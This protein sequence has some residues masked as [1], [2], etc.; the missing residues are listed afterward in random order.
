MSTPTASSLPQDLQ[1][2]LQ[3]A[4]ASLPQG[5]ILARVNFR[6]QEYNPPDPAQVTFSCTGQVTEETLQTFT[7]P[8]QAKPKVCNWKH[9]KS[10]AGELAHYFDC[11][12]VMSK[13][14]RRKLICYQS[15]NH[16]WGLYYSQAS[17][18]DTLYND[19]LLE[20]EEKWQ[21]VKHST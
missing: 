21:A 13:R 14:D 19:K 11:I 18:H 17:Q 2:L 15:G 1:T 4:P 3:A 12:W 6:L 20:L 9:R 10:S 5:G 16:F 7:A 8:F